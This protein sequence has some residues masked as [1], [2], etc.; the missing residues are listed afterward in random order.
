MNSGINAYGSRA[1]FVNRFA[2]ASAKCLG[3]NTTPTVVFSVKVTR[4]ITS[5]RR[6]A[7]LTNNEL[8]SIYNSIYA[9]PLYRPDRQALE[10][11]LLVGSVHENGSFF[12]RH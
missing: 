1:S 5:P 7:S 9:F 3:M 8:R 4:K 10:R 11:L 2:A 12:T 6:Y